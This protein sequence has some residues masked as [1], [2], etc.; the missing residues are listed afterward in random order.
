MDLMLMLGFGK[1]MDQSAMASSVCC[2]MIMFCVEEGGCS[3]LEKGI[4]L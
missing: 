1:T 4:K 3:F 2:Y